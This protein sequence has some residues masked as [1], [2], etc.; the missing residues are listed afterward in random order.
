MKKRVFIFGSFVTDL[1]ARIEIF[2]EVGET[3][4]G[5]NFCMGPGGKGSNQAVAANR[6]GADVSF[7]TR[8]GKDALGRAA[9]DFYKAEGF[10]T[11]DVIIDEE[12]PTGA[13]LIVV[14]DTTA[15]NQIVVIGGACDH[16]NDSEMPDILNKLKQFDIL[17]LQ[18]ETNLEPVKVLLKEAKKRGILTILNPAP[19]QSL[20][21]E[22]LR[23][24]DIITPNETE[25]QTLT[26][27]EMG[28]K[29]GIRKA[30]AELLV[31]GVGKVII[32]LG[33]DGAYANDGKDERF[34][35][36]VKYDTPVDT[37]GA[38]DAF[39]GGLAAALARGLDFFDAV[40]YGSTVAGIAVTRHGTAPAMPYEA[41]IEEV[42]KKI[43]ADIL[44]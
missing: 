40:L 9:L 26:G 7:V 24:I 27:V 39:N 8:L 34:F 29:D 30:A 43:S 5:Q 1:T 6:A 10:N 2:P 22:Y 28:D 13:A 18:L 42:F 36:I 17:L 37:T 31:S 23:C 35:D 38:G 4:K 14:N 12:Y 11:K 25:A 20:E 16:F 32:T 44:A 15:Q 3:V 33:D 19:A 41:E 21:E